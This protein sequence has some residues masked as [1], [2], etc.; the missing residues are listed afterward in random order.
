MPGG[1]NLR[2]ARA[3]DQWVQGLGQVLSA[4]GSW[5]SIAQSCGLLTNPLSCYWSHSSWQKGSCSW[6]HFTKCSL[7]PL[8]CL[9]SWNPTQ[10][11]NG[12][13]RL[14]KFVSTS[15]ERT[16]FGLCWWT[17]SNHMGNIIRNIMK[18]VL[19]TD[20]FRKG[21]KSA[22]LFMAHHLQW[23]YMNVRV[24]VRYQFAW[25]QNGVVGSV[26]NW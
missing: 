22:K 16:A 4:G 12:I 26:P 11:A 10:V 2:G 7:P 20:T 15:E 9:V 18:R 24:F 3:E 23:R 17:W 14:L 19:R 13:S 8:K 6:P 1:I 21:L 25:G 5:F